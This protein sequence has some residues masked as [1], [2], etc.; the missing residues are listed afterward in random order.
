MAYD[1]RNRGSIW[2]NDRKEKDEH[3]DFTG[4]LNVDG[5]E[6]WVNAWRRK[7]GASDKAPALTF[8][9]RPK[10]AKQPASKPRVARPASADMDDEI[11]F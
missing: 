6:Y 2:K 10:E 5:V 8:S 9:V 1:N 11:P 3:P 4:T 7:E